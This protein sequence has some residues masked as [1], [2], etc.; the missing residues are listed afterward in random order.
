MALVIRPQSTHPI[1]WCSW[2]E[3][4]NG[5]DFKLDEIQPIVDGLMEL[6][7]L[8]GNVMLVVNE[9]GKLYNLPVNEL[10]TEIAYKHDALIPGDVVRGTVLFCME[11]QVR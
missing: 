6:I 11:D 2:V 7:H 1:D 9:E 3:P 10:A 4:K 5:T 8:D